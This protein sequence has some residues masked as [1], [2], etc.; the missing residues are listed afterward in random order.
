MS[1]QVNFGDLTVAK[2]A[3]PPRKNRPFRLAVLGDF[4]AR[5]HRGEGQTGD[6]L[7][8]RKGLRVDCDNL[9]EV[10]ARLYIRLNLPPAGGEEIAVASLDD[11]HPDQL[12]DNLPV[13]AEL[14]GLL[15]RLKSSAMFPKAAQEMQR[16]PGL[17]VAPEPAP[18]PLARGRD[19]P[20][21]GKLSDFAALLDAPVAD[22][23]SAA[24]G[25]VV[26]DLLRRVV[27][28]HVVPAKDP[29]QDA[30]VAAVTEALSAA[31]REV[32]HHPDFQTLEALWRSVD[33][34]V[35][36]LEL[37]EKL[38]VVLYDV[39]AA[40]LAADLSQADALES[41][42]LYR[43]LVEAPARDAHQGPFSAIVGNYVFEQTPPHAELLGRVAKI[44]AAA[45]A[46]FLAAVA[47]TTALDPKARLHP[48]VQDAWAALRALPEAAF[49]ALTV[50][51]FLLRLPYGERTEPI[52]RFDFEEF[53]PQTG[54]RGMLWGNSAVLAGLLLG[55]AFSRQGEKM[56]PDSVLGLNEMP[57]Y[58]YQD[59]DGDQIALPC[60][61][62]FITSRVQE[63]IAAQSFLPVLAVKGAPEVR[64]GGFRSL[65][66]GPLKGWWPPPPSSAP[67]ASRPAPKAEAEA[68]AE[69]ATGT[70]EEP[71]AG[72]E[73]TEG[74][75]V[76]EETA[77]ADET[78]TA[79]ASS[80]ES[81]GSTDSGGGGDADLDALL[82]SL[83]TDA[84]T[85]PAPA[86]EGG[87]D[88]DLEKLLK[89]LG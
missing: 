39:T 4:S 28:P 80:A 18:R 21:D 77:V 74:E 57:Y 81:E 58:F 43:L 25:G 6:E 37:D 61:E 1:Y 83:G 24:D 29:R 2:A 69:D 10:M 27:A 44:A 9:D 73:A 52:D 34:L 47:P 11:L 26:G 31:M 71:T 16:W 20:V 67:P 33:L 42:G 50:P 36:R 19:V 63:G 8:A 30:M 55:T 70:E 64:L 79:E 84:A 46:P 54:L 3:P 75:S 53:T 59:A 40:E 76:A 5:A 48:L 88:P 85:P 23:P 65:A 78:G 72:T 51:G 60:T 82:A 49:V 35:R 32:L 68:E 22:K 13:F 17:G 86:E 87:M 45:G 15:Q 38:Q 56:H 7:A 89:D 66:G 14:S 12:Y 62:R 41:S